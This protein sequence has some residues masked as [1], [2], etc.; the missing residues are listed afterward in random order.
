M[1]GGFFPGAPRPHTNRSEGEERIFRSC[2]LENLTPKYPVNW[3]QV[4]GRSLV[5]CN[6]TSYE[7]KFTS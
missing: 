3:S 2:I 6:S 5:D 7:F 1:S 4:C